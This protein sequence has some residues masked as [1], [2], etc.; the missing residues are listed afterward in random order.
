MEHH[1]FTALQ[2]FSQSSSFRASTL[3]FKRVACWWLL[4]TPAGFVCAQ[5]GR[6]VLEEV[7]VT[8]TLLDSVT[9]PISATVLTEQSQ[10][11]RGAA[12]LEDVITLAPNVTA[13]SGAS[14]SRFFQIRGIGERSQFVEPVNPSVGI[15]L[16][17]IDLSGSGGALTLFDVQ[18]VEILR[19]PQG[20]LMGANALA[21]VI[22]VQ[23]NGTDSTSRDIAL[24]I[25]NKGGYRLGARWGGHLAD[26]IKGRV[27]LQQY[28]SDGYV[29]NDYLR[30]SN[31]NSREELTARGTLAWIS[32]AQ[33]V[34]A[35]V[36][37]TRVDNGYDAFS[38]DNTRATL[39]DQPGEDDL[40]LKAGRLNWH[41]MLMG[42]DNTLQ[43][44]HASTQTT[45]SYDED[46]SYVGIA[47]GWEY[48]S[49]DEYLRD[50]SMNSL[51]WRLQAPETDNTEWVIGAYLR[52]ESEDLSRRY[53][54]LPEPFSSSLDTQTLAIFGQISRPIHQQIFGFVGARLEQRDSEYRD[55]ANVEKDFDHNYWTGRLGLVWHYQ[56]NRQVYATLSRGARAGGANAG[57]LASIE[58]LPEQN[59]NSVSALGVFDEETLLSLE[60][61]WQIDWS[62]YNVQS[63]LALFTM[64]RNDQQAKGSLVIPR[65]DGST[66]F[67]DYTDNAAA[68]EHRGVEWALQWQ[69][70]ERL[71]TAFTL[72]LL[73]AQFDRYIT[74]T[75]ADLSGRDQPQAPDWQYS[76]GLT[77]RA[78]P[79]VSLQ[80]EM[81]G[82]DA[83]F[84]SDRHDVRATE[85]HQLNASLSGRWDR[86]SWNL[87]GR[88]LTDETTFV[89]AFG[90]F[91]NDPRKEYALEPYRQYGE[92]RMVGLSLSYDLMEGPQ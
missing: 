74:A 89:R 75:G 26:G 7:T 59:Q 56:D 86:W 27:A 14:R 21:G 37:Y 57:L 76:A 71:T 54:Y 51:E 25:E 35:A 50:R 11:R 20:T 33:T 47:P 22:A 28:E 90:T 41:S 19:G 44:S 64:D 92:P 32:G 34:E 38:L 13:S 42:L 58:A 43:L 5:E 62:E 72:G 67:I 15:L 66:A 36:Y 48:S 29:D 88:N 49:Y 23:S 69:P 81:A 6:W 65:A 60:V 4:I 46:W 77:W 3:L 82:S 8:A 1:V 10:S 79:L 61:G 78:T 2:H 55:S 31:T 18:Q 84:F 39:S 68:S 9:A 52:D 40:T 70:V 53:T 24:G 17:G 30:R 63:R 16:D 85:T 12:H 73:D 83:Y 91:G 80:V 45:Y 87:W